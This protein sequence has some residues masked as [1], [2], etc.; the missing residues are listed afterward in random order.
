MSRIVVILSVAL[1]LCSCELF[2]VRDSHPPTAGAP[3]NDYTNTPFGE[4]L[5]KTVQNLEYA[6]EDS[7]NTVY[8]YGLFHNDYRFYFAPQDVVDYNTDLSWD[9]SRERDMLLIL[10]TRYSNIKVSLSPMEISDEISSNEAK[11]FRT[12][13]ITAK[14]SSGSELTVAK[15][16]ME[17]HYRLVSGV[18]LIREWRDVRTGNDSTWGVLKHANS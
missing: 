6:F 16:S 8:Y 13:T 5:N 14:P 10:H 11:L 9:R 7:R 12:Y 15:G 18:W 4:L 2:E 3:W 1:F 17:L